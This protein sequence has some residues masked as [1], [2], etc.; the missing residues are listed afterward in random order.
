MLCWIQSRLSRTYAIHFT[1]QC[2][3][4]YRLK[5]TH[6]SYFWQKSFFIYFISCSLFLLQNYHLFS[7]ALHRGQ[8]L[9][10]VR[11]K[12]KSSLPFF[13]SKLITLLLRMISGR[14][15]IK[16]CSSCPNIFNK[17]CIY[18]YIYQ[19]ALLLHFRH[20]SQCCISMSFHCHF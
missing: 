16:H 13:P 4:N 10:V 12:T 14:R 11:E 2:T 19:R 5:N 17:C 1:S 9:K 7:L 15:T 20:I 8:N 6:L 18:I 3:H